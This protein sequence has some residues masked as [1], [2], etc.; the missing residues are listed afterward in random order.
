MKIQ[1]LFLIILFLSCGCSDT[2]NSVFTQMD[3]DPEK[4]PEFDGNS[5]TFLD[6]NGNPYKDTIISVIE[7]RRTV[8]KPCREMIYRAIFRS[9]K[10]KLISNSRIKMMATGKRWGFQAEKQD[11]IVIQYEF[12]DKDFRRNQKHQLNKKLLKN[13]WFKEGIEGVIE[14]VE[15]VWMHPFRYNQFNFT[16]VA[17]FPEVKFPLEI[18]K[19]W[20]GNLNIQD[21]WGDWENTQGYFEY[22][23]TAKET[24]TTDFGEIENCWKIESKS[25]FEFGQ[26]KLDYWFNEKLGF[27]KLNYIN[28]GNQTLEIQLE[29]VIEK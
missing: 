12:T 7:K 5:V 10:N 1:K 24:I 20:T 25:E 22:K 9:E 29:K 3:C 26:S 2:E 19:S 16:E 18:G 8:F 23:I 6:D 13:S 28:Y 14:N 15:E 4:M 17:P 11:E 21:G 27:V